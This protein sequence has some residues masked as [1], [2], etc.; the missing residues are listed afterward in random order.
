MQP[1]TLLLHGAL[2]IGAVLLAGC[3]EEADWSLAPGFPEG[4]GQE[5][6]GAKAYPPPPYG[7]AEG[8]V[9]TSYRFVGFPNA[10]KD[11]SNLQ[12][13]ELAEF[14]NPTGDGVYEEGSVMEI[15]APKPTVLLLTVSAVWCGPCIYEADK[16]FPGLYKDYKPQ[17]GEF[18]VQLADGPT[19]GKAAT[20]KSLS[21]WTEKYGV[22]YPM[23]IDPSYQLGAL[24]EADAF[25]ANMIID[26]RTMR[27][28]EITTGAPEPGSSFWKT[29]ENVMN[30]AP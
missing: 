28:I 15:G 5:P 11:S 22:D 6:L 20:A 30:G 21:A 19:P 7:V 9:I 12:E 24:F 23:A 14:Y 27:I 2:A 18:F 3:G 10:Q 26:T 8:S 25:P 13:I 4:T 29:Y 17:G 16:V 1:A